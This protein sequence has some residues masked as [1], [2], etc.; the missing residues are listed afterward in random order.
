MA[1]NQPPTA[2]TIE[3]LYDE[4]F[5]NLLAFGERVKSRPPTEHDIVRRRLRDK[6]LAKGARVLEEKLAINPNKQ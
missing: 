4:M 6:A 5:Q 3:A 2:E 1:D